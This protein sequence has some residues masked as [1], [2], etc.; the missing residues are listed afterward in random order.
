MVFSNFT[1]SSSGAI[2]IDIANVFFTENVLTYYR[3]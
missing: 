3:K 2:S 1:H